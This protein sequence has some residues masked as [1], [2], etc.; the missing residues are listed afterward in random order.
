LPWSQAGLT[1]LT[2]GAA[3]SASSMAFMEGM[4]MTGFCDL[5]STGG[6]PPRIPD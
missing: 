4:P 1:L 3:I 6:K 2:D 5:E